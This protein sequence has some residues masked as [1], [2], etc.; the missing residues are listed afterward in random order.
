MLSP[1]GLLVDKCDHQWLSQNTILKAW[2][3]TFSG[4]F[5]TR[6][7]NVGFIY[8]LCM[9]IIII[10]HFLSTK[11]FEGMYDSPLWLAIL[12]LLFYY[13]SSILQVNNDNTD[14][15][16]V[17]FHY[18]SLFYQQNFAERKTGNTICWSQWLTHE[19]NENKA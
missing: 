9:S 19:L 11:Y 7:F 2:A 15:S 6:E 1:T 14:S 3:A 18:Y 8:I 12:T 10:L 5:L 13:I 16:Y 17:C 4:L